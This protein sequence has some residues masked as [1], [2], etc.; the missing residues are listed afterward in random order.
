MG[1]AIRQGRDFRPTDNAATPSVVIVNDAFAKAYFGTESALGM[2]VGPGGRYGYSEI[3]GVVADSKYG[4][5]FEP[6]APLL[7]YAFAQHTKISS[8]VRDL[9]I[10]VRSELAGPAALTAALKTA[11][12]AV[13]PDSVVR[14]QTLREAT[15]FEASLW[16]VGAIILGTLGAV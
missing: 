1:M 5:A 3:I 14:I 15:S 2:R 7:Y 6:A 12:A 8:Q 13:Q 11:V 9:V 4:F 10:H 16:R